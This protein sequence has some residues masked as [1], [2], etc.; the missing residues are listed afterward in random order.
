ML[1]HHSRF[2]DKMPLEL[3]AQ[4]SE[5]LFQHSNTVRY[6]IRKAEQLLNLPENTAN[7]E[8]AIVIRS[9]LLHNLIMQ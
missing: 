4:R 5:E 7:E 2:P 6:R 8:M 9:Y 3:L 1:D